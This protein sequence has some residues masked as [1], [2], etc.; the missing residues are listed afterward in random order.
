MAKTGGGGSIQGSTEMKFIAAVDE[1]MDW[2]I[3]REIVLFP[4]DLL[5][6]IEL[7]RGSWSSRILKA[8]SRVGEDCWQMTDGRREKEKR[9]RKCHA[10]NCN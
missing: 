2:L 4:E 6:G 7:L 1:A 8:R 10:E 3:S 5:E 9:R